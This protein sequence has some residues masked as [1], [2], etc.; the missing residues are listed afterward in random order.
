M[1]DRPPCTLL[2]RLDVE[3]LE[4]L[5]IE[6]LNFSVEGELIFKQVAFLTRPGEACCLC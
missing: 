1:S 4:L 2:L 5:G 6:C 3:A